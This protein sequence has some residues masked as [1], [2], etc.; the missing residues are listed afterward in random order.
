MGRRIVDADGAFVACLPAGD[1]GTLFAAWESFAV[2]KV[3]HA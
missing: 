2:A 3:P 1:R